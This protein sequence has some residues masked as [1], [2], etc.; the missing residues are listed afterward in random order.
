MYFLKTLIINEYFKKIYKKENI[1]TIKRH[2][3]LKNQTCDW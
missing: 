3:K 2:Q 1:K